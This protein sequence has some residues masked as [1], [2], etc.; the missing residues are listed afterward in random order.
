MRFADDEEIE[1]FNESEDVG[2]DS[3]LVAPEL[4]SMFEY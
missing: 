2:V 4:L 3:T 1:R